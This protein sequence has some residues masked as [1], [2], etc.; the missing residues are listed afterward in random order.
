M[1]LPK[2]GVARGED[3]GDTAP[4]RVLDVDVEGK[5]PTMARRI[6]ATALATV[7]VCAWSSW[8]WMGCLPCGLP[9]GES[10]G[11]GTGRG[12]EPGL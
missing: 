9:P 5:G 6:G 4:G 12:E 8:I 11:G 10:R 3:L 1:S 7:G 2:A